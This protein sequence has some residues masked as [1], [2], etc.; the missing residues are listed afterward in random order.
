MKR[1]T[2]ASAGGKA[3]ANGGDEPPDT[4]TVVGLTTHEEVYR[5]LR[6]QILYGGIKP[7]S[8]VTLRGLADELGVSP[9]P[10][11]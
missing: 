2:G 4:H 11:R 1:L 3:G 9:M 10:V 6:E 5:R 8:A 7:G